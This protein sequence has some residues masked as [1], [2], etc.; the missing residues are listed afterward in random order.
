MKPVYTLTSKGEDAANLTMRSFKR[1][2]LLYSEH[3][4]LS[5]I[6]TRGLTM[7]ELEIRYHKDQYYF[8]TPKNKRRAINTVRKLVRLGYLKRTR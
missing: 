7:S 4:L 6:P 2:N 5:T 8:S 3:K 1:Y